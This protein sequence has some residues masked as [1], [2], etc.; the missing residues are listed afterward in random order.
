[1]RKTID[2]RS[3]FQNNKLESLGICLLAISLVYHLVELPNW[4]L[5]IPVALIYLSYGCIG[6]HRALLDLQFG[7]STWSFWPFGL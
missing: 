3:S 2:R 5:S 6:C 1:M 7:E 4:Q